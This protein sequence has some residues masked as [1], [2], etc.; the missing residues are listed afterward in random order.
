MKKN[1][2]KFGVALAIAAMT[3]GSVAAVDGAAAG[4][5]SP[6]TKQYCC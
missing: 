1:L 4:S 5:A 2:A 3:V 6:S